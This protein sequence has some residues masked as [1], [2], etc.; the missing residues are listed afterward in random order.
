MV[1]MS[2]VATT[3]LTG[4]TVSGIS[5]QDTNAA[6]LGI[7]TT[8]LAVDVTEYKTSSLYKILE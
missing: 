3:T 6:N 5:F 1:V 7:L 4:A 8:V 2:H